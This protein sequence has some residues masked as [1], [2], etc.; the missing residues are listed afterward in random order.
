MEK[1]AA[2]K[3]T[4]SLDELFREAE[5]AVLEAGEVLKR[6]YLNSK[7]SE[8]NVRYKGAIDPVTIADKTAENLI[9]RRLKSRFPGIK[10]LCEE[11]CPKDVK[12]G[13]FWILDPLDG[14]VNFV[15]HC[16]IFS[17]SLALF[18]DG[19]ILLGIINDV[20]RKEFFHAIK[21]RGAY[22]NGEPIT[23]SSSKQLGRSLLVTGFPYYIREKHNRVIRNF[24]KL[25]LAAQ[26]IRRL[27]SAALDMAWVASGRFDGFWEEGLQPWDVGAG[28]L[29]VKEAGGKV[30]DFSGGADWLFGKRLVA[31]NGKIHPLMIKI[32]NSKSY[33][34]VSSS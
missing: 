25:V 34:E 16:P 29:I 22:L 19:E 11:S 13:T 20:M 4:S 5:K 18:S 28:S 2:K 14:T 27:G 24:K 21:N 6:Y 9:I 31:S 17:T 15:H 3:S 8:L 33:K 32:L 7:Q 23:V 10:F 30:S 1:L 12:E 26:G